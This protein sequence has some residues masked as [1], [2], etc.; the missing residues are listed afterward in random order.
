MVTL[1]HFLI[2]A[3]DVLLNCMVSMRR[4]DTGG[5]KKTVIS[6]FFFLFAFEPKDNSLLFCSSRILLMCI[7]SC[8]CPSSIVG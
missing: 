8:L 7:W 4:K 6:N 2:I 5:E 3:R 1:Y